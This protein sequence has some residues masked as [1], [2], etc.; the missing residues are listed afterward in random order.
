M[1]ATLKQDARA[2]NTCK[3]NIVWMVNIGHRGCKEMSI[4]MNF[5]A[6]SNHKFLHAAKLEPKLDS[7]LKIAMQ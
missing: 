1:A 5:E 4:S 7:F 6:N 2:V 3:I